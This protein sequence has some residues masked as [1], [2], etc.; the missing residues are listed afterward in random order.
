MDLFPLEYGTAVM[1]ATVHERYE[2][3]NHHFSNSTAALAFANNPL[4]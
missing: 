1:K 3:T 4:D 2:V